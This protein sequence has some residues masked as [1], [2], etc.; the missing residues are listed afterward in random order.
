MNFDMSYI[1]NDSNLKVSIPFNVNRFKTQGSGIN[2]VHGGASLQEIV[3][4]LLKIKQNRGQK[5][6]KVEVILESSSRKITNNKHKLE[7]LQKD[8]ISEFIKPRT[9]KASMWDIENNEQISNEIIIDANIESE[10]MQDRI[11]KKTLSLKNFK[12]DKNKTYY[13]ILEDINEVG[14]PY[15]KIPFTINLLFEADF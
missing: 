3:V 2:Y 6:E 9:I 7:F 10:N 1:L 15:A 14:E 8:S 12:Q 13:L 4:P 11:F 5:A